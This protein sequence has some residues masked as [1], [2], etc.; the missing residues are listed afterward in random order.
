VTGPPDVAPDD[1]EPPAQS[2]A[3]F[4][5]ALVLVAVLVGLALVFLRSDDTG[6]L[7]RPERLAAVDADT[8]RATAFDVPACWDVERAQVD[9]DDDRILLELVAVPRCADGDDEVVDVVAEVDLPQPIEDRG[10]V[11][12]VGRTRLPCT[13]VGPDVRCAPTP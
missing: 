6:E 12:G 8:V 10:L 7:V 3:P 11:A 1:R 9:Y 2:A 4:V 13:G 5:V